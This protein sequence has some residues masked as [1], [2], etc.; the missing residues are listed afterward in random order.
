M[1][2]NMIIILVA[3]AGFVIFTFFLGGLLWVI[4]RPVIR[5]KRILRHGTPSEG[6]IISIQE[7]SVYVNNKPQA[8]IHLEVESRQYGVYQAQTKKVL[9]P[10]EIPHYQPG[11]KVNLKIDPKNPE[12]VAIESV[13]TK[14]K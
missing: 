7:T 13:Q 4:L 5:N 11:V 8:L 1:Q 2:T 10:F 6:K 14:N 3:V 9:S 12:Y